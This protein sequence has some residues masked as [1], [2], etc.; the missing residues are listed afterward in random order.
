MDLDVEAFVGARVGARAAN[1]PRQIA[2]GDP[3]LID[4]FQ[5]RL[6]KHHALHLSTF[7]VSK[8]PDPHLGSGNR[9]RGVCVCDL[10]GSPGLAKPILLFKSY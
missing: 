6:H 8:V 5:K 4:A 7:S 1:Q 9:V 10:V 3:L 2:T